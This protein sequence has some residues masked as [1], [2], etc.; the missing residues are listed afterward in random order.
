MPI[1]RTEQ[2]LNKMCYDI[3]NGVKQLTRIADALDRAYPKT[4]KIELR[5]FDGTP[6][7]TITTEVEDA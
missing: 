5:D 7:M 6:R 4:S 1:S 2:I 3:H